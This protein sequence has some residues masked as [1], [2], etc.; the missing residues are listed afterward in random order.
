MTSQKQQIKARFFG[1]HIGAQF[2]HQ[3]IE[4]SAELLGV[5]KWELLDIPA[6][7]LSAL[8]RAGW[9]DIDQCKLILRPLASITDEEVIECAKIY[10]A[11]LIWKIY[12]R[13]E[14]FVQVE[15]SDIELFTIWFPM[16][17]TSLI[18]LIDVADNTCAFNQFE[19]IDYLRS[20]SFVLPFMG[21]DPVA[22]N[23][24]ILETKPEKIE[25]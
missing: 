13:N 7:G 17:D 15:N 10:D 19:C 11:D 12:K 21:V 23:W 4:G 18:T 24:A 2:V 22:E 16:G 25:Q 6:P 9:Y 3:D 20:L 1:M 14:Y 8:G 5:A